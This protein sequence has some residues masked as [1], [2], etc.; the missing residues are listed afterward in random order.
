[1][2]SQRIALA[3]RC[4]A[5]ADSCVGARVLPEYRGRVLEAL[6]KEFGRTKVGLSMYLVRLPQ[7][8]H[9]M[10]LGGVGERTTDTRDYVVRE[11]RGRVG[12]FLHRA[13]A[14]PVE[15]L[16]AFVMESGTYLDSTYPSS[17]R[18]RSRIEGSRAPYVLVDLYAGPVDTFMTKSLYEVIHALS[19][20]KD[21]L[22]F[23]DLMDLRDDVLA[24][25]WLDGA[26][27]ALEHVS[28]AVGMIDRWHTKYCL[29]GDE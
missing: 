28:A 27:V 15:S 7:Y 8:T 16:E 22:G 9:E 6:D 2:V 10:V 19:Q 11:H 23:E 12:A 13:R 18:E 26:K 24:S 29:V 1:M 3:N 5:F 21:G 17:E 4:T 25:S 14:L 20:G